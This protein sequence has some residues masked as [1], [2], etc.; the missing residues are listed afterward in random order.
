MVRVSH[1]SFQSS[2]AWSESD[3]LSNHRDV[4]SL[5]SV[6]CHVNEPLAER[7]MGITPTQFA[8]RPGEGH[9]QNGLCL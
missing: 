9:N 7:P 5:R 4:V 2:S 6:N 3:R 1:F 8:T